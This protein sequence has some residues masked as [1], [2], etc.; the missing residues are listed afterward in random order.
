LT[1]CDS[2]LHANGIAADDDC[3]RSRRPA[4]IVRSNEAGAGTCVAGH[5]AHAGHPMSAETALAAAAPA[6]ER[7]AP[8]VDAI[9]ALFGLPFS[10]LL[11]RAQH[12]HRTH[13]A[14]NAVQLSTLLSIKTGGCPEDS[15]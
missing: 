8:D 14:P 12:V 9:D 3:R 15:G 4:R 7:A 10:D 1:A 13:H 11:L 6:G 5:A 2:A